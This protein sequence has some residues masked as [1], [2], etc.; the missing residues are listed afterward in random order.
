MSFPSGSLTKWG[1][2][3][4]RK[5]HVARYRY[6]KGEWSH[7]TGTAIPESIPWELTLISW[8]LALLPMG[9]QSQISGESGRNQRNGSV[10][11]V[12]EMEEVARSVVLAIRRY[13]RGHR[14]SSASVISSPKSPTSSSA[15]GSIPPL[16]SKVESPPVSPT[17]STFPQSSGTPASI[18]S[19]KKTIILLQQVHYTL[20]T[21]LLGIDWLRE[22][23][24]VIPGH[25]GSSNSSSRTSQSGSIFDSE[26]ASSDPFEGLW[27]SSSPFGNVTF[28]S[29][30]L[31]VSQAYSIV[32][33]NSIVRR[34]ALIVD[35]EIAALA[36]SSAEGKDDPTSPISPNSSS[37]VGSSSHLRRASISST[38]SSL[39]SKTTITGSKS[40]KVIR[41]INAHLEPSLT[42]PAENS[43]AG[44]DKGKDAEEKSQTLA[45]REEQIMLV[46]GCLSESGVY[47]ALGTS[48]VG[49]VE[50]R[51][52][53]PGAVT[54]TATS[55]EGVVPNTNGSG[56][57]RSNPPDEV[58]L[59][60]KLWARGP[61]RLEN[62]HEIILRT[63]SSTVTDRVDGIRGVGSGFVHQ[64]KVT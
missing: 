43:Q 12:A 16:G 44:G 47:A 36:S 57:K 37:Q 2:A 6:T 24:R 41:V 61:V 54:A 59:A 49:P 50:A 25:A 60:R 53:T 13:L 51:L 62:P 48:S 5:Q 26:S 4:L 18:S 1:G 64:V 9:T 33:H 30:K 52:L 19:T 34:N 22:N 58:A 10:R 21:A 8:N 35:L 56:E 15:G 42:F 29:R 7:S 38:T 55:A 31:S 46:K 40:Q 20:F 63:G 32:F 11:G 27:P 3:S 14:K 28:I 45:A 39:R 23:F 17:G